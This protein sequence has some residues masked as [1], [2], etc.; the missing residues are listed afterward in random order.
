MVACCH[1]HGRPARADDAY[2]H[3]SQSE[4]EKLVDR[5]LPGAENHSVEYWLNINNSK[6]FSPYA[7]LDGNGE[8]YVIGPDAQAS[9]G[10]SGLVLAATAPPGDIALGGLLVRATPAERKFPDGFLRQSRIWTAWWKRNSEFPPPRCRSQPQK[11][12]LE[13]KPSLRRVDRRASFPGGA[14]FRHRR[15]RGPGGAGPEDRFNPA[16]TDTAFLKSPTEKHW[17]TR[18]ICNSAP[19]SAKI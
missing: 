14:W 13:A 19:H 4:L 16:I 12:F 15:S 6:L 9:T 18:T 2:F 8:V 7:K 17:K 3:V 5:K 1:G 11:D 10:P